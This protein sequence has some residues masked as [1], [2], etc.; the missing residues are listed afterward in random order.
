[1]S[2]P[3]LKCLQCLL[4]NGLAIHDSCKGDNADNP[5][6]FDTLF[7]AVKLQYNLTNDVAKV[8]LCADILVLYLQSS[9]EARR[10]DSLRALLVMLGHKLPS[11]R[12]HAAELLYL[13]IL[14]DPRAISATDTS[15]V[16]D[17]QL[18]VFFKDA[19]V[20]EEVLSLLTTTVWEEDAITA[21]IVRLKVCV[22]AGVELQFKTP[23]DE[24]PQGIKSRIDT[25]EKVDELES[26]SYLVRE[27]GR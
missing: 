24:V 14:S 18:C 21:R 27:E 15:D 13:H 1:M 4:E 11:I 22:L 12:K 25:Y 19:A 6:P 3:M 20:Y 9:V 5:C 16:S 23:V 10:R 26:Y 7:H 2:L 17:Q 8:K